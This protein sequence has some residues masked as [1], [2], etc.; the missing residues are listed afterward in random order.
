MH[1]NYGVY[2]QNPKF[3]YLYT[4]LQG[5]LESGLPLFGNPNLEPEETIS[6]ELGL[7]HLLK[8]NVR[9]DV[10]AYYKDIENLVSTREWQVLLDRTVTRFVNEDYGSVKGVDLS[11]EVL[12]NGGLISAAVSYGYMIATGIG[13][14]AMEPYYTYLTSNED[15]LAPVKEYHL[16]FDQRHTLTGV[17]DFRVPPDYKARLFGVKVPTAWGLNVVGYYGSGLPYTNTD[18]NGARLAERN[19][20]RLPANYRVDMRLNKDFVVGRRQQLLTVFLE[21]DNVLN[22]RN[23]LNVYTTTGRPDDDSYTPQGG[24]ALDSEQLA[25][26]DYLYD[27]DP[28]NFSLPRTVRFGLEFKF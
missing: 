15:T 22:R 28:E 19:D 9:L 26:L 23:I 21:V 16:D 27:H 14:D 12:P 18:V 7:D 10:T 25:E 6:Y 17:F 13:S 2:Y 4:N 5:E 20:G 24:L 1:F 8:D 3:T 11:L